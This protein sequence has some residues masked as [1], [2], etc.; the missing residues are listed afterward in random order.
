[1]MR[2][3][4]PRIYLYMSKINDREWK[5]NSYLWIRTHNIL[6]RHIYAICIQAQSRNNDKD[7]DDDDDECLPWYNT[8]RAYIL[9]RMKW[10][11]SVSW[12][13][14]QVIMQ[15]RKKQIGNFAP[16]DTTI[17]KVPFF[18]AIFYCRITPNTIK[19]V[20]RIVFD[21]L[22]L[23]CMRY[24]RQLTVMKTWTMV[25][26]Q[27]TAVICRREPTFQVFCEWCVPI[28]K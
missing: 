17:S 3:C 10:N 21:D 12:V 19:Y 9:T 4:N 15:L 6:E 16:S 22:R 2:R 5:N 18:V 26:S 24:H 23:Q 25:K 27:I 1:M 11:Q 13:G 7:D 14:G 28:G 20:S 8:Y